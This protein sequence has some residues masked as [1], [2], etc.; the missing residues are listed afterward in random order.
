VTGMDLHT[1]FTP[2]GRHAES[3]ALKKVIGVMTA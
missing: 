1:L 2:L 3:G